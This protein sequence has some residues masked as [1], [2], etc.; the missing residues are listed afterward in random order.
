MHASAG[1]QELD[2][3]QKQDRV[4]ELQGT[5]PLLHTKGFSGVP[6]LSPCHAADTPWQSWKDF[7]SELGSDA[8]HL[9]SGGF[10]KLRQ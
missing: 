3:L 10:R 4:P 7:R 5:L 6:F 1:K 8:R 2:L 9:A